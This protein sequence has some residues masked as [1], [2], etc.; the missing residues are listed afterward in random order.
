MSDRGFGSLAGETADSPLVVLG[1]G[2]GADEEEIRTA[3]R[4]LAMRYHPDSSGDPGTARQFS[5]VVRA[6]KLLAVATGAKPPPGGLGIRE[7]YRRVLEAGEDLFAL[8]QILASDPDPGARRTAAR[9]LGL[10]GR[11]AAYVFLRRALYDANEDVALAAVRAVSL[12]GSR[13][14]GPEVAALF[15]R[16]S[17]S[18][19]AG[20]LEAACAT[21]ESLFGET[22]RIALDDP[23]PLIRSLARRADSELPRR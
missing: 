19:R 7:R 15:S 5:R 8:G 20:I 18:L 3:Y 9:R 10:S 14:A 4:R 23:D 1:L 17:P 21:G 11:R 6:Y 22:L 12:L 16:A 2:P 13:Q